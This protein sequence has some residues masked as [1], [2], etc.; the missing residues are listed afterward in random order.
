M[1]DLG[2]LIRISSRFSPPTTSP[3]IKSRLLIFHSFAQTKT[4][5]ILHNSSN[6]LTCII[7]RQGNLDRN[8]S[9]S[10]HN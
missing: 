6:K 7:R 10:V 2:I 9:T 5:T 3:G 8:Y 4:Y 1:T